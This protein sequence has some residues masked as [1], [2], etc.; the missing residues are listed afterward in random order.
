MQ[1]EAPRTLEAAS[2]LL[3]GAAGTARVLAG[4]TDLL[5]QIRA[6]RSSRT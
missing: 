1:Y 3:A 2:A 6:G 4:G 5:V